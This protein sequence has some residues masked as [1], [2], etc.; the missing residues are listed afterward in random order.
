MNFTFELN[1]IITTI[2]QLRIK[3]KEIC[4]KDILQR[5]RRRIQGPDKKGLSDE[6]YSFYVKVK[7]FFFLFICLFLS[8]YV[9]GGD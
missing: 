6:G 1:K 7:F 3:L 9:S 8:I 2:Q 4:S 5:E